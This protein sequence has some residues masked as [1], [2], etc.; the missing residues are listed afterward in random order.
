MAVYL[1]SII[2][3]QFFSLY[4]LSV[5]Y[6]NSKSSQKHKIVYFKEVLDV[7]WFKSVA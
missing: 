1:E 3:E 7:I 4:L 2:A 5:L 6:R